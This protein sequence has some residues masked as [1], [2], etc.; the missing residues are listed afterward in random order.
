MHSGPVTA[1]VLKGEKSRF[2]LFGDT[3]NT[4]SRMES[5]GE[6][7]RIQISQATADALI[8]IGK[9]SW[10]RPREDLVDAKGKGAVKTYW[11]A[12][13]PLQKSKSQ[14][15]L[16]IM[17]HKSQSLFTS[18]RSNWSDYS[19][20]GGDSSD[21]EFNLDFMTQGNASTTWELPPF[22]ED[23]NRRTAVNY[24]TELLIK[25]LKLIV[26]KRVS[27]TMEPTAEDLVLP[28]REGSIVLDEVVDAIPLPAFN[29]DIIQ[30]QCD[31]SDVE[32]P[33]TVLAQ[34]HDYVATI[35]SNYRS[36]PF[37]NFEHASHVAMSASKWLNR[38]IIPECLDVR[39]CEELH[40]TTDGINTCPLTQF[41]VILAALVHD[42]DHTGVP[43]HQLAKEDPELADLY[44]HTSLAE[45]KSLD[46]AWDILMDA[47]YV[48]LRSCIYSSQEEMV[49]FRQLL[50]NCVMAT[51]IFDPARKDLRDERWNRFWEA[52]KEEA[53]TKTTTAAATTA[54]ATVTTAAT[55]TAT[56]ATSK[57][58]WKATMILEQIM[59]VSDIAHTMQHW[60]VYR[61]WNECL[62]QERYQA[63]TEGR[64]SD[65]GDPSLRWYD[66][67]VWF[68]DHHVI[69]LARR[70][71]KC[72]VFGVYSN[73]CLNYAFE[74]R[75][76][77]VE[78]G[79]EIVVQMV[80]NAN[81][82]TNARPVVVGGWDE[83]DQSLNLSGLA[84]GLDPAQQ[85]QP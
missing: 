85:R 79:R 46:V 63:Y 69:P 1:G 21:S 17:N 67:E 31:P 22:T 51:E 36:L 18:K 52:T 12:T 48:D 77:W 61:R 84:D 23:Q 72:D 16:F 41:A 39:I 20:Q 62:F 3:V 83:S 5:T 2:Q 80:A 15:R 66:D 47:K 27:N 28:Q 78:Q 43:N 32:L 68:F 13:R 60:Q 30:D 55:A 64:G 33:L 56:V 54:A 73:E 49:R 26:S 37:H 9:G 35:A 65:D 7:N 4:A 50:V 42:I 76:K 14:R 82:T 45:Q 6:R 44:R 53:T 70:L 25:S 75:R 29:A 34:L 8:D 58:N 24:Q 57:P 19:S 10:I 71:H 59:Q 38:I 40:V 11:I 81:T 74:N